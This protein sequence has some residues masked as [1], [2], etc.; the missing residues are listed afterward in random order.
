AA[1]AQPLVPGVPVETQFEFLPTSYIFKAGHHIRLTL[2][3]A[4]SRSTP[5]A[6]PAPVVTVLHRPDAPSLIELPLR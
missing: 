3:F 5:K 1:S 2:Q 6:D 4:D